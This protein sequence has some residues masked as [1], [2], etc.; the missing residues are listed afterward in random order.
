MSHFLQALSKN[1]IRFDYSCYFYLRPYTNRHLCN[2]H[3]LGK[4][5]SREWQMKHML[6]TGRNCVN[7]VFYRPHLH[8]VKDGTF[9]VVI[10]HFLFAWIACPHFDTNGH[11]AIIHFDENW[12]AKHISQVFFLVQVCLTRSPLL[13]RAFQR[14]WPRP[15]LDQ[16]RSPL[17][18]PNF[19]LCGRTRE[20]GLQETERR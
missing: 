8:S 14:R 17:A 3:T 20:A 9:A 13:L 15:P 6:E 10:C 1:W 11:K 5:A 7:Y 19:I 4:N 16:P 18:E 2:L 12:T